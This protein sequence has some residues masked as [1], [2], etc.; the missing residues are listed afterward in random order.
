MMIKNKKTKLFAIF[1]LLSSPNPLA[2]AQ[3]TNLPN[4]V[5]N[6]DEDGISTYRMEPA[7]ESAIAFRGEGIIDAPIAK[8]VSVLVD[9]NKLIDWLPDTAEIRV[10]KQISPTDWLIY[11]RASVPFPFKDRDYLIQFHIEIDPI[12]QTATLTEKSVTD[13][14]YPPLKY[15]RGNIIRSVYTIESRK[16]GSQ[17]FVRLELE[18]EP[19]GDIP[20]WLVRTFS[21]ES[22]RKMLKA[23]IKQATKSEVTIDPKVASAFRK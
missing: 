6:S 2:M 21:K 13:P 8:V 4:W 10:L 9:V 1:F 16:E 11:D 7:P 5:L 15:V 17:T 23:L 3:E 20:I 19:G 18:A 12:L 22:P 14:A